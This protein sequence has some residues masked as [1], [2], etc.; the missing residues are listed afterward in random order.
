MTSI[1]QYQMFERVKENVNACF[2][3]VINNYGSSADLR[4]DL[5]TRVFS[6]NDYRRLTRVLTA[7][8]D[9]YIEARRAEI[10]RYLVQG[11]YRLD[12]RVV[13]SAE[14]RNIAASDPAVYK[15]LSAQYDRSLPAYRWSECKTEDRFYQ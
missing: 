8:L 14:L 12:G 7:Y 4:A 11:I 5:N 6:T 1:K 3:R 9:G 13:T 15:R 2:N 10:M